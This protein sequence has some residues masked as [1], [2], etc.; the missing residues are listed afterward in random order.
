MKLLVLGAGGMLGHKIVQQL[1]PLYET[2]GTMRSKSSGYTIYGVC[3]A[4][5]I[6]S[7]IDVTSVDRL[8][9]AISHV[10]PDVIVNC[11]GI[12]KQREEVHDPLTSITI[13]SLFPHRLANICNAS[14]IRLIHISTD[15]VFSGTKGMYRED[16]LPDATDLYGRTKFLGELNRPGCLTIRTSVIG[17]ELDTQL[18][19]VEWFLSQ[20]NGRVKG[21]RRAIYSGFTTL[22]MSRIISIVITNH[23]N[24]SGLYH[25][26]SDPIDKY[27]LLKLIRDAY[28]LNIDLEATDNPVIDRSLDS[29]RFRHITGY[30]PPS[31]QK[32]ITEMANDPTP[33]KK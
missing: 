18:G 31:W 25:V 14:R 26:S 23:P 10:H 6:L 29:R 33:Y 19:L 21:Y 17:R 22:E 2:W 11:V 5:R 15:C 4:D 1:H 13:N 24:I 16:D 28:R 7:N 27:H 3:P 12:I 8:V 9:Q 30:N 32:M 20:N